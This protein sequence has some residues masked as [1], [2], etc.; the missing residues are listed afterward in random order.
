MQETFKPKITLAKCSKTRQAFGITLLPNKQN[1]FKVMGVLELSPGN[2]ISSKT[3]E[4]RH[5]DWS[6]Y[7][8]CPYCNNGIKMI[9]RCSNCFKLLCF[10]QEVVVGQTFKSRDCPHCGVAFSRLGG[11]FDSV[12]AGNS[13]SK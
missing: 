10:D 12:Q 5:I 7:P 2:P 8:G 6:N 13:S 4:L 9:L 11:Y 1:G 3:V